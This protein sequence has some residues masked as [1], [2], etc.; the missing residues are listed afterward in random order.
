[1]TVGSKEDS[2]LIAYPVENITRCAR[3]Y[4]DSFGDCFLNSA[5]Q[6][7]DIA[8]GPKNLS[9][10][11][12]PRCDVRTLL[13]TVQETDGGLNKCM[14]VHTLRIFRNGH[15]QQSACRPVDL[16]SVN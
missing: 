1:M 9:T 2:I 4:V 14:R 16:F 6:H 15:Q 3:A 5:K 7:P 10:G 11:L 13:C 12:Q 8:R